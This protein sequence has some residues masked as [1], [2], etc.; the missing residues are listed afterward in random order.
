MVVSGANA[1]RGTPRNEGRRTRSAIRLASAPTATSR[2]S[3]IRS[4]YASKA[5]TRS[6]KISRGM[7]SSTPISFVSW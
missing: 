7:P 1:N 2:D 4:K 5:S 6:G 3:I